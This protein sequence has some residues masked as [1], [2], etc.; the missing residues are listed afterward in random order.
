MRPDHRLIVGVK[1]ALRHRVDVPEVFG[2]VAENHERLA[3]DEDVSLLHQIVNVKDA[4]GS[5]RNPL[6]EAPALLQFE[7]GSSCAR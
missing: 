7:L 1:M 4:R 2:I 5:C 6:D 3:V